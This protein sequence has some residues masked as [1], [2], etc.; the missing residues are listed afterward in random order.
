MALDQDRLL[1]PETKL[2]K[3]LR[4]MDRV[5]SPDRVHDLRRNARRLEAISEILPPD[6]GWISTA[7]LKRLTRLRKRA[8]MVRDLD[9]LTDY[10]K[11]VQVDGED[12]CIVVL[13][14]YLGARRKKFALRLSAGVRKLGPRLRK[15]LKRARAKMNKQIHQEHGNLDKDWLATNAAATATKLALQLGFPKRLGRQNLHPYRLKVKELC[16]VLQM[17][18]IHSDPEFIDNL[19]KVKDAIGEWHDWEVLVSIAEDALDHRGA[20][21]L[22]AQ[23]KKI[24]SDKYGHALSRAGSLRK[25]YLRNPTGKK[26]K[27]QATRRIPNES[28]WDTIALLAS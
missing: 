15:D 4:K 5:P 20:C 22:H 7:V 11:S 12:E 17:A 10:A 3:L 21:R 27:A 1:K 2:R 26:G 13:L 28:V 19:G 18:S 25:R 8:G 9:V 14:E 6:R 16:N 23:I 24:A